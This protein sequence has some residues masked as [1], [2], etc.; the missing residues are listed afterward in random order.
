MKLVL[1]GGSGKRGLGLEVITC[2]KGSFLAWFSVRPVVKGVVEIGNIRCVLKFLRDSE[3]R[4]G[5]RPR[6]SDGLR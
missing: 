3:E 4:N 5:E 2:W 6:N 1:V